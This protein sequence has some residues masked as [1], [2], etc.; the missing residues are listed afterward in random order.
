MK[1]LGKQ[2]LLQTWKDLNC[3]VGFQ[4]A[5]VWFP[6]WKALH[7]EMERMQA[8]VLKTEMFMYLCH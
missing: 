2:T 8:V 6:M 5:E 4:Y 1:M 3:I 7:A